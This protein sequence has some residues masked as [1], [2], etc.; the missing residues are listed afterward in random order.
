MKGY[1]LAESETGYVC[2]Y[3][4]YQGQ[5]RENADIS[6]GVAHRIVLDMMDGFLDCGHE[7]IMDN[8][9]SSPTLMKELYERG[10]F[11]YGTLRSNR[12]QVPKDIKDKNPNQPLQKGEAQYFT[13][14]PVLTGCWRDRNFITFCSNKHTNF[15]I[16]ELEKRTWDDKPIHKPAPIVDYNRYMGGVDLAD[17][18]VKYYHMDRRSVKWYRK[19]FFHL[20]DIA[21]HNAHVVYKQHKSSSITSLSFRLELIDQLL[22]AAGPD[23]SCK[24]GQRGRPRSI[25]TDISRLNTVNHYPSPNP[26]TNSRGKVA[27]R[28]CRICNQQNSETVNRKRVETKVCCAECGHVPLCPEPC[29]RRWHTEANI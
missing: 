19:L 10:T 12:K 15:D 18:M 3:T 20:L 9:Y 7:L 21:V 1:V 23:P 5:D 13:C 14:P 4:L 22:A 26:S 11:A 2:R 28:Q 24:G 6:Q 16:V 29:F 25:G 27:A 17:Q 8:W